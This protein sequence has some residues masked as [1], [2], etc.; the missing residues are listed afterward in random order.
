MKLPLITSLGLS[1]LSRNFIILFLVPFVLFL[2][3]RSTRLE[4]CRVLNL[5]VKLSEAALQHEN[6]WIR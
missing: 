1:F 2:N 4:H 6:L 5:F 3:V